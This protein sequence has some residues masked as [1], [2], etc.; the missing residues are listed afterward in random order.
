MKWN[1][2]KNSITFRILFICTIVLLLLIPMNMVESVIYERGYLYRQASSEI[3]ASWGNEQQLMGP[4]LTLPY[5]NSVVA[6]S[7]WST[8][9]K[10]KHLQ[11]DDMTI[12]ANIEAQIR[13]RGIFKVP[14]YTASIH[15]SGEFYLPSSQEDD[16]VQLSE[17][18]IQIP[19]QGSRS[20][21]EPI[22]FSWDNEE[23]ALTAER[24]ADSNDTVIF[25]ATL[26]EKLL[27]KNQKHLFE[28][29]V[30]LAGSELF[31]ILSS[32]KHTQVKID[33]NWPSPSFYGVHLPTQHDISD[34]GFTAIWDLTDLITELH[35]ED[36][37]KM[38]TSWFASESRFGLKLIQPVDTYQIVTRATKY[39]VLFIG[40][41]F[42][43][44]FF[45]ELFEKTLLHP[46]QYLF[47][48][49]ANCIFYLL[50]LSLA[51]HIAFTAAYFIS[52]AASITLIALYSK[53]ILKSRA[54][55]TLVF[56]V[57]AGLYSY[58]FVTLRSEGFA[59]IIGSVGLFS[60]LGLAMYLTRNIDW[61]KMDT[62]SRKDEANYDDI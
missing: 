13:Y 60:I 20:I 48:G 4:V 45:V 3:A 12:N 33:S 22:N 19:I 56:G 52:A 23:V 35:H 39:A 50:L 28:Y 57:L 40:L 18:I 8:D 61:H 42:L 37:E 25:S 1:H 16:H 54:K 51:E 38:S 15:V 11:A 59:L 58:L 55:A 49:I 30:T 10:N 31:S 7:G 44:Y 27:G 5:V 36:M 53:S 32:A 9:H 29:H 43:I 46:I 21:K 26:P 34:D 62:G 41:T 14:V 6:S 2:F 17:G 47:V 24:D